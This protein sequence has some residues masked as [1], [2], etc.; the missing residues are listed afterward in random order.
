MK[1]LL[2][3]LTEIARTEPLA[4]V[5]DTLAQGETMIVESDEREQVR[6]AAVDRSVQSSEG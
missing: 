5:S 4:I 2:L 6:L 3:R 1:M